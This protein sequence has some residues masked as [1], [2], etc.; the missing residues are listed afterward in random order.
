M[1]MMTDEEADALDELLTQT[2]PKIKAGKGGFF[3]RQR[4]LLSALDLMTLRQTKQVPK[5]CKNENKSIEQ[6]QAVYP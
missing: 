2:T 4:N 3:I 1:A 5:R 6:C